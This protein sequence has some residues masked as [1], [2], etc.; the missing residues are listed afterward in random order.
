[1]ERR[2]EKRREGKVG[3]CRRTVGIAAAAAADWGG[4][5]LSGEIVVKARR[6]GERRIEEERESGG[7]LL[8]H[9]RRIIALRTCSFLRCARERSERRVCGSDRSFP[10]RNRI[11][12]GCDLEICAHTCVMKWW[13]S[14]EKEW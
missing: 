9:Y 6:G 10:G 14:V 2:E 5:E 4:R 11:V 13:Q 12:L 8:G 1:M 7:E 3:W